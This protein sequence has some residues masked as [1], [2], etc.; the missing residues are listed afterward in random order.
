MRTIYI[1]VS[2]VA[3]LNSF[4]QI[5]MECW[6]EKGYMLDL[7][8]TEAD[9][10]IIRNSEKHHIGTIEFK[11]Y[12]PTKENYINTV[13]PFHKIDH[14]ARNPEKVREIDKVSILKQH[15]GKNLE[16]LIS[17]FVGYSEV[18]KIESCV[19]LFER[20]FFKALKNFYKIPVEAVGEPFYY[21][22]DYVIPGVVYPNL[23]Y[24][25]KQRFPWLLSVNPELSKSI[26]VTS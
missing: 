8:S 23:I 26:Y 17:L 1:K 22:G 15:R 2:T 10:F 3:D 14:L 9:Q 6:L 25:E 24:T 4:N 12:Y 21:K 11:P 18:Y 20:V 7:S 16:R 19:G 13:F 5:W